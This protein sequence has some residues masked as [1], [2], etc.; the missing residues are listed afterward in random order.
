MERTTSNTQKVEHRGYLSK[1]GHVVPNWKMRFFVL[2][3]EGGAC[4]MR[5]YKSAQVRYRSWD[6]FVHAKS[7][8][9]LIAAAKRL[10]L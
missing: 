2:E 7:T 10:L 8:H 5:Y 9:L 1:R 4:S 6:L 3:A